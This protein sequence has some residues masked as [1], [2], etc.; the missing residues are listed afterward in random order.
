MA[1]FFKKSEYLLQLTE[2]R[3]ILGKGS[4][5][6]IHVGPFQSIFFLAWLF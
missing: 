4:N 6:E 1:F 5:H 3:I 2:K